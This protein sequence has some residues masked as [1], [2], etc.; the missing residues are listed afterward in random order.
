MYIKLYSIEPH[1]GKCSNNSLHVKELNPS[2]T[3][4]KRGH[5][6]LYW[7]GTTTAQTQYFFIE[8]KL[9]DSQ[10][11]EPLC[12]YLKNAADWSN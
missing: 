4:D 11:E 8:A 2:L 12:S 7:G 9:Q 6:P 10:F 3:R 1:W 5:S